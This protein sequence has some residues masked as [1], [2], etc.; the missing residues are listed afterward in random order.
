VTTLYNAN[1][2]RDE[3]TGMGGVRAMVM[4]SYKQRRIREAVLA[5]FCDPVPPQ[6]DMLSHLSHR[7]WQSLLSWMDVSGLALYF[8]DRWTPL[9]QCV[10]LPQ[11]VA[12]RLQQN[13]HDNALRTRSMMDESL[14]LQHAF[15]HAQLSYAVLKGPSLCPVAV[16]QLQLRHQFDLDYLIAQDHAPEARQLLERNGYSLQAISGTSWEF[17]KNATRYIPTRD[18]YKPQRSHF[19]ELHIESAVAGQRTRLSRAIRRDIAGMSMPVL[20]PVD[21]FLGQALHAFKDV[22]SA[23]SRA[24]HLLEFRRHVLTRNEDAP[25]WQELRVAAESNRKA[26]VG[27]GVVTALITSIMGDFAPQLLTDWTVATLPPSVALWVE[28]YGRRAVFGGHPGTKLYLLLQKELEATGM[29]PKRAATP[30]LVPTRMP[31]S[32]ISAASNEILST[33]LMRQYV[34]ARYVL[35]RTRFHLVEGIRYAVESYRWRHRLDRLPS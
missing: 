29:P 33:R 24:A 4:S 25:F 7:E 26:A 8:L 27:I 15:Q 6:V 18:L 34:Q 16:P 35:G 11:A 1:S 32:V 19:V 17:K 22:C 31:P 20:S 14:L 10:A 3:S 30:L 5:S 2:Y 21:L 9:N 23:F 12:D 13:Q 28:T